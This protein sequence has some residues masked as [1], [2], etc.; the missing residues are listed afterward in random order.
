M[1]PRSCTAMVSGPTLSKKSQ[2]CGKAIFIHSLR[3]ITD[4][5]YPG[6]NY[7]NLAHLLSE[8]R[9]LGLNEHGQDHVLALL[10]D[11]DPQASDPKTVV[12]QVTQ[13]VG[14]GC[15]ESIDDANYGGDLA[16]YMRKEVTTASHP[17]S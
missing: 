12:I 4:S 13:G 10:Y 17:S 5:L 7:T 9:D 2:D 1:G 11:L 3:S 15:H 16:T 14:H 8:S 6:W